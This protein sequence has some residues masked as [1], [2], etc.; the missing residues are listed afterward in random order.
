MRPSQQPLKP[1]RLETLFFK[2][3]D[4]NAAEGKVPLPSRATLREQIELIA[5]EVQSIL[6]AMRT[7]DRT[8]LRAPI[9]R[10][11]YAIATLYGRMQFAV[12]AHW[13]N[14][15]IPLTDE[16]VS[17]IEDTCPGQINDG[18]TAIRILSGLSFSSVYIA[19]EEVARLM[20]S[21]LIDLSY[22]TG[23]ELFEDLEALLDERTST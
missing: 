14:V 10:C 13:F 16:Y 1:S 23:G 5:T 21:H 3:I 19:V 9:A 12:P 7:D 2:I 17:D 15:M 6:E 20:S 18:L 8:Q 4:Q 22:V 11:M